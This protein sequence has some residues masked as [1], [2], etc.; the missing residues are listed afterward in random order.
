MAAPS[1]RSRAAASPESSARGGPEALRGAFGG[2]WCF[3]ITTFAGGTEAV[4]SP[5]GA[6]DDD[7]TG[8]ATGCAACAPKGSTN[9][10]AAVG[11]GTNCP[12]AIGSG[13]TDPATDCA[14]CG[15]AMGG[16]GTSAAGGSCAIDPA[17]GCAGDSAVPESSPTSCTAECPVDTATSKPAGPGPP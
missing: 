14:T 3:A 7:T 11:S 15:A 6:T 8:P 13:T 5:E 9:C 16:A 10:P 1:A 4:G 2:A 17:T 12:A